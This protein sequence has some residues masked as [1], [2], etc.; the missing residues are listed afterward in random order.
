MIFRITCKL[1]LE[2]ASNVELFHGLIQIYL[3]NMRDFINCNT[4]YMT[5]IA[6]A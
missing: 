6:F 4:L 1:L 3:C 5:T 2:F